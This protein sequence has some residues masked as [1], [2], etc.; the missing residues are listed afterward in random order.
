ME[1]KKM[2]SRNPGILSAMLTLY[3]VLIGLSVE[4]KSD[5]RRWLQASF[6]CKEGQTV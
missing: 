1:T 6:P 2:P 4:E 3:L 5:P